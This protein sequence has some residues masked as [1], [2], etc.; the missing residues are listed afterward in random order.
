MSTPKT[1][2]CLQLGQIDTAIHT[3]SALRIPVYFSSIPP[4]HQVLYS[5]SMQSL[6]LPKYPNNIPADTIDI[7][8]ACRCPLGTW[9]CQRLGECLIVELARDKAVGREVVDTNCAVLH[10]KYEGV[11]RE[12]LQPVIEAD[13]T[14]VTTSYIP[15]I[16]YAH[17]VAESPRHHH[18]HC[19]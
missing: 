18:L 10:T 1:H 12:D 16:L 7:D 19:H 15:D 11:I 5:Q 3:E 6:L 4:V 14:H 17:L 9:L 13:Y 2:C 8:P